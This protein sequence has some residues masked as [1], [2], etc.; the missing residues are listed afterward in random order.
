MAAQIA[1]RNEDQE[2]I[3]RVNFFQGWELAESAAGSAMLDSTKA[4]QFTLLDQAEGLLEKSIATKTTVAALEKV[5]PGAA[6]EAR[7]LLAQIPQLRNTILHRRSGQT[8]S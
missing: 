8:V 1:A 6:A 7:K 2:W 5:W 4:E 3:A